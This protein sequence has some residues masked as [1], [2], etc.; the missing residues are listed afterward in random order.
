MS[1]PYALFAENSG[2]GYW[3][4]ENQSTGSIYYDKSTS[5]IDDFNSSKIFYYISK[6]NAD[7]TIGTIE[8]MDVND[9]WSSEGS[10]PM[11]YF[12]RRSGIN[13]TENDRAQIIRNADGLR[14]CIS[15]PPLGQSQNPQTRM[16]LHEN[17]RFGIG[18]I[19]PDQI[20][21]V[22]GNA[23]KA[24]GGSWATF[25]DRRVKQDIKPFNEGLAI[26][27]QLQ[28]V[29]Y[30][31]NEK[32]GYS[33]LNKTFV[34]FIAQDVEKIAPYMVE[35]YNDSEGPSGLS[36]KRQFDESALSKIMLNSIKEQQSIIEIQQKSIEN[37]QKTIEELIKR[38]EKLEKK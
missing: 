10:G 31:Y 15:N 29:T 13:P 36:D 1:V 30:K 32:S 16:F 7:S 5:I 19:N 24:G 3:K 38:I 23:S 20:L 17:G 22:N 27:K 4:L 8:F 28:P 14:F 33:D 21:S 2:D 25:S 35:I 11:L 37:Q 9:A 18:T 12:T 34:G 6:C 26:L